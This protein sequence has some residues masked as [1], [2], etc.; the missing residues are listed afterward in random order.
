MASNGLGIERDEAIACHD[1][2]PFVGG[3]YYQYTNFYFFLSNL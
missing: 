2:I 3:S 1:L